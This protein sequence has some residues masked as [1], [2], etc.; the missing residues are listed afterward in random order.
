M[1][2]RSWFFIG[3]L[4]ALEVGPSSS[5]DVDRV[6]VVMSAEVHVAI[7]APGLPSAA[8]ADRLLNA[9]AQL[10]LDGRCQ[11]PLLDVAMHADAI[12]DAALST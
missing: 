9:L 4:T 10:S 11:C 12:L 3:W 5:V 2:C 1:C 6:P 8:P 7:L